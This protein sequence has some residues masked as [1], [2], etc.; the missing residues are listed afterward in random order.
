[1]RYSKLDI[2]R[3]HQRSVSPDS[4]S[5]FAGVSVF[6]GARFGVFARRSKR[7]ILARVGLLRRGGGA[8]PPDASCGKLRK[9]VVRAVKKHSSA[10]ERYG[11]SAEGRA[12]AVRS[13]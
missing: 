5:C 1:M 7:R 9:Q 13:W 12:P 3:R 6:T 2:S 4:R 10:E 8:A 11:P